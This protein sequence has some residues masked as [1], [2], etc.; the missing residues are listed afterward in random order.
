MSEIVEDLTDKE[1]WDTLAKVVREALVGMWVNSFMSYTRK[2][3]S[4]QS[5]SGSQNDEPLGYKLLA[6]TV[7]N[8]LEEERLEHEDAE[9]WDETDPE[10]DMNE[11][12]SEE[13]T[14]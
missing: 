1:D 4:K 14:Q 6:N 13:E 2:L 12:L 7:L 9:E 5:G 10:N 8:I 3:W 11:D